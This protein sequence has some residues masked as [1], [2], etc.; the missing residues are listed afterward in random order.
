TAGRIVVGVDGSP[1]SVDALR[2]AGR[3]AGL[4]GSSLEAVASWQ[5]PVQY[6]ND[7]Y[8]QTVDWA[9]LAEDWLAKAVTEADLDPGVACTRI[10]RQGHPAEVLLAA[11]EDADLLVMGS[12]G[13]GGFAGLLLGSV[14]AHVSAHATCPVLV[15]RHREPRTA[16]SAQERA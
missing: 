4:T 14:S 3:Q 15:V 13:H 5:Y 10:V 6:G 11:A 9:G 7:F 2:W 8:G 1:A 12:R 16:P